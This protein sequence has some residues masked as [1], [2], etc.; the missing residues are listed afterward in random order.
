V[1]THST[2][3]TQAAV[4]GGEC[5]SVTSPRVVVS[6][7]SEEV[8]SP[9]RDRA[10]AAIVGSTRSASP[11]SPEDIGRR[12]PSLL[13]NESYRR[14]VVTPDRGYGRTLIDV[15]VHTVSGALDVAKSVLVVVSG[16]IEKMGGMG[17][18][19]LQILLAPPSD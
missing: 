16:L 15:A 9:F 1:T 18:K 6:R 7:S 13:R 11:S 14:A 8:P 19:C 10:P 2:T 12:R 4:R 17:K 3:F 5:S